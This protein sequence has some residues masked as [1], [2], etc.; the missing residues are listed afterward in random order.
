MSILFDKTAQVLKKSLDLRSINQQVIASNIANAET[1]GYAVQRFEFQQSLRE[2]LLAER[3]PLWRTHARHLP[4]GQL[5]QV[6]GRLVSHPDRSGVGD[7]NS[8][9]VDHEMILLTENQLMYEA[10]TQ[11]LNKKLGILKY[12]IQGA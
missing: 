10:S 12:A 6:Q 3:S 8:V 7:G 9:N 2:A 5:D 1:P 4:S 11:L